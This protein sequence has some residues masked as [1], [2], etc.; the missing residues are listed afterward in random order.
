MSGASLIANHM[1]VPYGRIVSPEDVASSFRNGRL[2]AKN[3]FAN[4]ILAPFFNEIEP[5]LILRC[6][7]EVNVSLDTVNDLYAHTLSLGFMPSPE[8]EQAVARIQRQ[9]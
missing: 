2:S 5:S 3:D 8:W 7:Y 1:N 4:G 6:A 9:L